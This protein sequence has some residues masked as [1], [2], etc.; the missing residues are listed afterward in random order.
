MVGMQYL[1]TALSI[2]NLYII[3]LPCQQVYSLL[4]FSIFTLVQPSSL[5]NFKT[6]SS[7]SKKTQYPLAVTPHSL[8]SLAPGKPMIYFLLL[9]I[10]LFQK[11]H[12]N[13]IVH[14]V[15]FCVFLLSL[16]RICS[17]FIHVTSPYNSYFYSFLWIS[18]ILSY[19]Y[20][21]FPYPRDR[22]LTWFHFLAIMNN[23]AVNIQ[24]HSFLWTHIF[25]SFLQIPRSAT[26][27]PYSNCLIL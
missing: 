2:H 17:G 6:F 15:A 23:T 3:N 10:C 16:S 25:I 11:F 14:Y 13:G 18:N 24:V 22:H 8:L 26:V 9:Q 12:M 7:S 5:F 20:N 4:I 21:T 1:I 19:G 27:G